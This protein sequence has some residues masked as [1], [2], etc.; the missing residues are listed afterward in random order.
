MVVAKKQK[1][2]KEQKVDLFAP[3]VVLA[4][5]ASMIRFCTES[6][7]KLRSSDT[8]LQ[9]RHCI[10]LPLVRAPAGTTMSVERP[11]TRRLPILHS[12][13]HIICQGSRLSFLSVNG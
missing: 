12:T 4:L 13:L 2:K 8:Q 5:F 9:Q 3:F 7:G 10:T 6:L 1:G 11:P